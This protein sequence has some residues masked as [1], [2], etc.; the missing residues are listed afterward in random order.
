ML[1]WMRCNLGCSCTPELVVGCGWLWRM[2]HHEVAGD[3]H[4]YA[5]G[6]SNLA[7][8]SLLTKLMKPTLPIRM[9][10]NTMGQYTSQCCM[11]ARTPWVP[12]L[13]WMDTTRHEWQFGNKTPL[14]LSF[15]FR[16]NYQW[17]L[18]TSRA[19][20]TQ[21]QIAWLEQLLLCGTAPKGNP[22]MKIQK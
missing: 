20:K 14:G 12:F 6:N 7:P 16:S 19:L 5:G 8:L 9:H 18:G 1:W 11:T 2:T 17:Y 10:C 15:Q 3:I 13:N 21:N 4:F 22:L